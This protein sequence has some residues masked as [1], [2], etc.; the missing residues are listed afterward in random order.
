LN[1]PQGMAT[2]GLA[3]WDKLGDMIALTNRYMDHGD[4]KKNCS[5]IERPTT[6]KS[7]LL[8]NHF[9]MW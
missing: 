7:V 1:V 4:M 2:I 6:S 5:A 8:Y 9:L 3:E